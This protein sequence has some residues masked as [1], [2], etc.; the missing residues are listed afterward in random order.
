MDASFVRPSTASIQPTLVFRVAD[1]F[2]SPHRESTSFLRESSAGGASILSVPIT[3]T[4][5][6]GH[7][8]N[9]DP[10]SVNCRCGE[11]VFV[12]VV[13]A[14]QFLLATS[15]EN[16]DNA[17]LGGYENLTVGCNDRGEVGARRATQA[18]LLEHL[19]SCLG[20]VLSELQRR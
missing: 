5:E 6:C 2:E 7:S 10:I 18:G 8:S 17:G 1:S 9:E 16:R 11:N 3:K 14:Q 4:V 19:P 15:F 12:Q 13:G 20:Q